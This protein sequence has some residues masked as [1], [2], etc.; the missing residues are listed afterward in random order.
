MTQPVTPRQNVMAALHGEQ[1][2]SVPFTVYECFIPQCSV[3]RALRNRGLCIVYRTCS[4][5]TVRPNIKTTSYS[6]SDDQ[7]RRLVRATWS[8]PYGDLSSLSE[9][10]GSTTW[11]HEHL[12]KT[13]EDYKPLLAIIQDTVLTLD[14]DRVAKLAAQLGE[15][16]VVRDGLPSEPLQALISL[17]MGTQTFCYEWMDNRDEILKLYQAMVEVNRQ[18]YRLVADGPLDHANYGGNV[19]P[20]VIGV[21]VFK[22]YYMPNYNEAAEILHQKGKLIGTHLDA[23][24]TIIMQAVA[25]TALDYI[26]AY[27]AGVSPPVKTAMHTWPGKALWLNW[28]SAWHLNSP[29]VVR[30][31]TRQLIEEAKPYNGLIIGITEDV[32]EERWQANFLAIMDGI[33]DCRVK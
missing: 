32:P 8:T 29:A 27:D 13:P 31:K 12:F 18:A 25:E 2:D 10:V 6:Y 9:P 23:D 24:N 14:Y 11:T 21:D 3:E 30:E 19:T 26:E 17:Y 16:F 20:S 22:K 1:T 4:Y 7:G 28:P 5:R 15:D 33:D